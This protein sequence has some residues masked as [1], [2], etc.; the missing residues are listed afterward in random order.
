MVVFLSQET[1]EEEKE[2][3]EGEEWEE[4]GMMKDII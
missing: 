2:Y 1:K 3:E 4:K